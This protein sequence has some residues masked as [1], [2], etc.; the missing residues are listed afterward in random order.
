MVI[1]LIQNL[2]LQSSPGGGGIG[3]MLLIIL[4]VVAVIVIA[5]HKND[6]QEKSI[7]NVESRPNSIPRARSFQAPEPIIQK[8]YWDNYKQ[9]NPAKAAEIESLGFDFSNVSDKEAK[10]KIFSLETTA[11]DTPCA[12][13]ELK[14]KVFAQ[15]E[16]KIEEGDYL[17][18]MEYYDKKT[19]EEAST[20]NIERTNTI[21]MIVEKWMLEKAE[22]I[23]KKY[24]S[25]PP[26]SKKDPM[27][28]LMQFQLEDSNEFSILRKTHI[29]L[30]NYPMTEKSK[31]YVKLIENI[32][33]K[34]L[35]SYIKPYAENEDNKKNPSLFNALVSSQAYMACDKAKEDCEEKLVKECNG[36]DVS[37]YAELDIAADRAI[38][39][40]S[41]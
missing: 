26:R 23:E 22:E 37:F 28:L 6:N 27:T 10:E 9:N 5:N 41:I 19:I 29:Y 4:I 40:Y 20:Y 18:L 25:Q 3:M 15:Y 35:D 33:D 13:S 12:I 24:E 34:Y 11:H 30:K 39:K 17:Y 32:F 8:S 7:S 21:W 2:L 1:M 14:Q 36:H 16:G 38:A 31:E